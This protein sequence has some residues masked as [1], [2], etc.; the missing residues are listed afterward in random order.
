MWPE[1]FAEICA[2]HFFLGGGGGSRAEAPPPPPARR[3]VGVLAATP[4]PSSPAPASA[5]PR[6][7]DPLGRSRR[8]ATTAVAGPLPA[9]DPLPTA[10]AR[11][12]TASFGAGRSAPGAPIGGNNGAVL[13]IDRSSTAKGQLTRDRRLTRVHR[14]TDG[15]GRRDPH[16]CPRHRPVT[17]DV[18]VPAPG[19]TGR[20]FGRAQARAQ[21]GPAQRP[22]DMGTTTPSARPTSSAGCASPTAWRRGSGWG[23]CD[24]AGG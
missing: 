14:S 4:P 20:P 12:I 11:S 5:P 23:S 17:A 24:G 8:R 22:H 21:G 6:G 10:Q 13:A 16:H 9:T 3:P 15:N 7:L 1:A 18:R 19:P 2:S